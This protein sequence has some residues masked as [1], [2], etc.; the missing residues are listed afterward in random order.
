M[1]GIAKPVLGSDNAAMQRPLSSAPGAAAIR[2]AT[3][4]ARTL[5]A[6]KPA[7]WH[8]PVWPRRRACHARQRIASLLAAVCLA[9]ILLPSPAL[10][11][12]A[13]GHRLSASIAWQHLDAQTRQKI[14]RL[15]A[16]H[17]DHGRWLAR[18]NGGDPGATAFCEAS[19]WP[20]EIK[21]DP[22]FYDAGVDEP[23][24]V[25]PGFPDMQRH[26]DWH[27]TNRP[28][29]LPAQ[30][31]HS[32]G[33]LDKRLDAL[34]NQIGDSKAEDQ[35]RA[36]ALPWLIHLVADAHQPLHAVSRYDAKGRGDEGGN[37]LLIENPWHP[38]L[39]S[40]S[41]H[42]YWDDLPAPPWLRG[43]R[44]DRLAESIFASQ[45]PPPPAG[46]SRVWLQES[47]MIARDSAYPASSDPVPAIS[48]EFDA[49]AH[50]IAR[51]RIAE[52][53]YRLAEWL[54]RLLGGNAD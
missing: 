11:W 40:M 21:K 42:A 24:A 20:D 7:A 54:K 32:S 47:W 44:L 38:R 2:G 41:L 4:H 12:N 17:P 22:R 19:T 35:A 30:E 6:N 39:S 43:E 50:S 28:L 8:D 15:L 45:P 5:T 33:Q 10:A 48:A 13:A 49:Q 26:R 9:S 51:Q 3:P 29:G 53:A 46:G 31:A 36:Y 18:S 37:R 34:A 25:L 1:T 16:Q 23:T 52:S 14:T 27:Y